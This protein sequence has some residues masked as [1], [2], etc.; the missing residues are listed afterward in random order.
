MGPENAKAFSKF[1]LE[2]KMPFPGIPDPEHVIAKLYGQKVK[3]LKMGRLPALIVID[4]EGKVRYGHYGESMS[5]IPTDE[6]ILSMLDDL[7]KESA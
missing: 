2:H 4:K 5:D 3:A 6:E 1:W 7:N